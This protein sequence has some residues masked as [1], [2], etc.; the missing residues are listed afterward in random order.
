MP[1]FRYAILHHQGVPEPHFDLLLEAEPGAGL[2]TWRIPCWPM[3]LPTVAVPLPAHRVDYL[4]YEGPISGGR[5]WVKRVEGGECDT[6][7]LSGGG[8][9]LSLI[10]SSLTLRPAGGVWQAVPELKAGLG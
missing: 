8:W 2:L 7:A 1:R 4:S 5:G 9:R 6:E 3:E 10:G